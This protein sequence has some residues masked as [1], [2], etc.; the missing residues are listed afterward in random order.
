MAHDQL[1]ARYQRSMLQSEG[2]REANRLLVQH[3]NQFTGDDDEL[4]FSFGAA[5][6]HGGEDVFGGHDVA[7]TNAEEDALFASQ[8]AGTAWL[9]ME[10]PREADAERQQEAADRVNMFTNINDLLLATGAARDDDGGDEGGDDDVRMH[11]EEPAAATNE[12]PAE[13]DF[14]V[15]DDSPPFEMPLVESRE[16]SDEQYRVGLLMTVMLRYEQKLRDRA[17][18]L[19]ERQQRLDADVRALRAQVPVDPLVCLRNKLYAARQALRQQRLK[20]LGDQHLRRLC[21]H[22]QAGSVVAALVCGGTDDPCPLY[23]TNYGPYLLLVLGGEHYVIVHE[24][25]LRSS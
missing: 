5:N 11:V 18:A 3:H 7:G 4:A 6:L 21:A 1:W 22:L 9:T 23:H 17:A 15:G 12:E 2:L 19:R 20:T 24:K 13:P 10:T 14:I 16:L 25:Y 8:S